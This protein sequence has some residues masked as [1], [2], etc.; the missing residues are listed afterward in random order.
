MSIDG[1]AAII[2]VI[3]I[4]LFLWNKRSQIQLQKAL[5]PILYVVMYR[6]KFGIR[7]MERLAKKFPRFLKLFADLSII[8]GF[9]G[10]LL[11]SAELVK[12]TFDVLTDAGI[13]GI[14][15]VLPI[16]AK[17]VFFVPFL[18][19]I[20]SIFLLALVHE[21]S[22]GVVARIYNIPVKSS[23]FAFLCVLL[24]V[25]PAAFVEPDEKIVVKRPYRQ[26]LGVFAAGPISNLV[27]AFAMFGLFFAFNPVL[28]AAFDANGVELIHVEP[29]GPAFAAGLEKG[30]I[31]S[32]LNTQPVLAVENMTAFLSA[33]SPGD[34][35]TI[36]T[37]ANSFSVVL[38]S[39]PKNES[40]AYLGVQTRTHF[41]A[42]SEFVSK[43]GA[44]LPP[45]LKWF[46]GLIFWLFMLNIGIGL[47]NLLP[48]GPLDGGRMF[49]LVCFKFFKNKIVALKVW[50]FVSI[51][52]VI[53]ILSNLV[54]GFIR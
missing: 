41:E 23:G 53:L 5:F 12:S 47:F 34:S 38:A 16:E 26:Q 25:I 1:V 54:I 46:T 35:I 31:I 7:S 4:G 50:G 48:I 37:A 39:N 45:L 8:L 28:N 2:F 52:F 21:F 11:I 19:W 18:Y 29:D 3:L 40:K 22:H 13:P 33:S 43:Y 14:Q 17:G 9:F 6:S 42:K 10:M 49:Q 24:P 44:W 15:P 32:S 36:N 27:F 30:D 51:F 20:L